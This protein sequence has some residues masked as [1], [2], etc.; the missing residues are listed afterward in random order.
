MKQG[1]KLCGFG[2]EFGRI[3][4][5]KWPKQPGIG[6]NYGHNKTADVGGVFMVQSGIGSNY[7][8]NKTADV[9]GVFMVQSGIGGNYG[10]NKAGKKAIPE[11]KKEV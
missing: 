6:S 9:G 8:H 11:N 5:K 10:H 7:G 1:V 2:I 4:G 3:F